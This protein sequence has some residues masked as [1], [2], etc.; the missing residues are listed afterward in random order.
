MLQDGEY[1]VTWVGETGHVQGKMFVP[2]VAGLADGE[3]VTS[4]DPV[5]L[6]LSDISGSAMV[7][8]NQVEKVASLGGDAFV[9]VW[10]TDHDN[11]NLDLVGRLFTASGPGQWAP[12]DVEIFVKDVNLSQHDERVDFTISLAQ[13]NRAEF[14]I[15]YHIGGDLAG[16]YHS[17]P[18]DSGGV[19]VDVIPDASAVSEVAQFAVSIVADNDAMIDYS[20]LLSKP[21]PAVDLGGDV[22]NTNDGIAQVLGF[23]SQ[24]I[25][26]VDA[27]NAGTLVSAVEIIVTPVDLDKH[28]PGHPWLL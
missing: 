19:T 16:E 2:D 9:V 28:D 20:M 17:G 12:S 15:A 1:I 24:P 5:A 8:Q 7:A 3:P 6:D 22:S 25:A 23:D 4:F 10:V 18:F 11:G 27:L 13:E 14:V 21:E 26:D